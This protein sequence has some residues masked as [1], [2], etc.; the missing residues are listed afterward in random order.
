MTHIDKTLTPPTTLREKLAQLLVIRIGSDMS[1]VR[2]VEQDAERIAALLPEC[3]VGGL[4]I[5][6]GRRDQTTTTLRQV[7][8]ISKIPL[9]VTADIERG[10]GQ[11][12]RGEELFPHA[13]AFGELGA[14]AEQTVEEFA[15]LTALDARA[16]GLHVAFAPVA[17]VNVDPRNPII[18]TRAFGS[19]PEHVARL[20]SAFVRG[21]QAGG[22]LTTAKHFPGHGNT[23]EDSHHKLPTVTSTRDELERCELVPFRAAIAAGVPLVMSAH[24]VYPAWD[25]SGS[26]ATLSH[27]IL[28]DLLREEMGFQGAVVSDSLMMEGVKSQCT[29]EGDLAVNAL[30]AGVDLLLDVADP[31]ATLASLEQ[32]VHDGRL[33]EGRVDEAFAR[34]WQLKR[35]V[36]ENEP[37]DTGSSLTE[38]TTRLA[39]RVA[40]DSIR[41]VN[42]HDSP[43]PFDRSKSTCAILV[44]PYE[45]HL[46]PP[47]QPLGA[48]M[49]AIAPNCE[50]HEIG[51]HSGTDD[52]ARA[53]KAADAAEQVLV[54]VVVKP[55]AWQVFGLLPEQQKFV[56]ELLK[57]R[58]CVL[59]SLGTPKVLQKFDGAV[60]EVCTYSDVPASQRALAAFGFDDKR[61]S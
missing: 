22:L 50:F 60:V 19:D 32:A 5:F 37:T 4:V 45:T 48:A 36:F 30:M 17:D 55:A 44:R 33:P 35:Q 20:V 2:T 9:L 54:A 10:V 58:P 12:L 24:V 38:Q 15:H 41:I 26:Q 3:P 49:H 14:A 1:P 57:R 43:L 7:Q 42:A 23:H 34:M 28:V 51:R 16:N 59:A 53:L 40:A 39:N 52:F 47:E 21:C 61:S 11:Q 56:E 29:D 25:D 13:M 27:P 18:A 31:A 8:T 46:D 6:N